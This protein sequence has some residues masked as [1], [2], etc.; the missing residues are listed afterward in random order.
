MIPLILIFLCIVYDD[1]VY[2]A[3]IAGLTDA[4]LGLSCC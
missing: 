1:Y 4:R 2:S 3:C